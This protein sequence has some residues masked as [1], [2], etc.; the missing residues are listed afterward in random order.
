MASAPQL[1]RMLRRRFERHLAFIRARL[2]PEGLFGLHVTVGGV[3][4]IA[5]AWL[6]GGVAEDL[7]TRDPLTIVDAFISDWFRIH[8]TPSFTARMVFVSAFASTSAALGLCTAASIVLLWKRRWYDLLALALVVPGGALLN[9]ML[10]MAFARARP[11]WGD[12]DLLG[13]SFPSGHTMT[14]TL[15]Y[16]LVGVF[17]IL[18]VAQSWWWRALIGALVFAIICAV[19]FSRIYLGAHYLSDVVAAFAA[20]TAWLAICLTAVETLRRHRQQSS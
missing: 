15:L 20:G 3:V 1:V 2:S 5:A 9:R 6:F 11:G 13:Y 14:A 17:C 7:I 16:G 18:F 8:A 19:G 10:K 4:L 12:V